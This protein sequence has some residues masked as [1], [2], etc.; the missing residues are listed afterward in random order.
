MPSFDI[1]SVVNMQEVRNAVDQV[2][3]EIGTRY[4]FKGSKSSVELKDKENLMIIVA[5]DKMKL[6][7][8]QE[9]MRQKLAKRGVSAKSIEWKDALTVGG[10]LQRQE[11]AIKQGFSQEESKRITKAIKEMKENVAAQIQGEQVR[12]SGKKKDDLQS[13]MGKL[14][15]D[16]KELELQFVNFRE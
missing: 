3:R 15:V 9:L 13:V 4:D 11:L 16:L 2:A 6:A 10:D 1:V 7:S 8:V 5:D 14:R 12:V